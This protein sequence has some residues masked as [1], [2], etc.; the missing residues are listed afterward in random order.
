MPPKTKASAGKRTTKHAY[1]HKDGSLYGKGGMKAGKPQG[2]WEWFRK[3]GT[4]MRSG[5]FENGEQVG[6]WITYDRTGEP[7]KTTTMSPK[8]R[9]SK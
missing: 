5:H 7:F 1:Y 3:D 9:S 2:Y 6:E 8:K 4:R